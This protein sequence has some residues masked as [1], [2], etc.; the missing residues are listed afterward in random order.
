MNLHLNSVSM[1]VVVI[2]VSVG[3]PFPE[4]IEVENVQI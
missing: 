2:N 3:N 1:D 4:I